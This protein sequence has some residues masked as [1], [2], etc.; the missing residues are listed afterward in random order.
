MRSGVWRFS[1]SIAGRSLPTNRNAEH[2]FHQVTLSV[3][4]DDLPYPD[5]RVQLIPENQLGRSP[6]VKPPG[7]LTES[8]LR[9]GHC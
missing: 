6:S 7:P 9:R 4:V 8:C 5:L 1:C 3:D 2:G